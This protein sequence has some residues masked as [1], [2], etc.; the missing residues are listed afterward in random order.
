MT[1]Q[2][3]DYSV[4][5]NEGIISGADGV[6]YTF[7]GADWP[8]GAA[9]TRGAPVDFETRD[10]N[11]AVGI[12]LIDTPAPAN[13]AYPAQPETASGSP[14]DRQTAMLLALLLG[15]VGAHKFYLGEKGGVLRIVLCCTVFALPVAGILAVLDTIKL[16][17]MPDAEFHRRY[18]GAAVPASAGR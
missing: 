12:Y 1:G 13:P 6:R 10:G 18:N 9:P 4:Q 3:L 5:T 15:V 8:A 7:S 2:V 16:L 17:Q 14:K 11:R